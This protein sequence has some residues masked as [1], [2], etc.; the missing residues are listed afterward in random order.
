MQDFQKPL[1]EAWTDYVAGR[2]DAKAL[3][4]RSAGF[5]IYQQR[6]D[7]TMMRVRRVGGRVTADDLRHAA[8]LL[9]AHGG[10]HVHLTTRQD[11]QLHGIPAAHVTAALAACEAV[12]F[13]FR[14][15]GATPSATR[16]SA[17][18]PA[19]MRIPSSTSSPTPGPS[20]APSPPS[21]PPTVSPASSRSPLRTALPTPF[22]P[23][24]TTSD[25]SRR[26]STATPSSRPTSAAASASN[27]ASAS[28]SSTPCP[29][30]TASDSRR[31]SPSSST[32]GAAARTARTRASASCAKTSATRN[33]R[34]SSRPR[35]TGCRPRAW[36]C[37]PP[38]RRPPRP[39]PSTPPRARAS[40]P[41]ARSP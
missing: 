23:S 11:L 18:S 6:D 13:H 8:A 14:G 20:R 40:T 35:S 25:S 4:G 21:T 1:V 9:R 3:K 15:G 7:R 19:S 27:R 38:N 31:P 17:P 36:I 41:G 34:A 28:G 32:N 24:R 29:P 33:S 10:S 26:P 39:F 37:L 5:G 30:R 12:G 22:S 16:A 2:L